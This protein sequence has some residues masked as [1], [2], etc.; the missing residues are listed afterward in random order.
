MPFGR[1]A[2]DN[3]N[4]PDGEFTQQ[5]LQ[6]LR[7][8]GQELRN[9]RQELD[10]SRS[11]AKL[12]EQRILDLAP[13]HPLPI[14]Q[15]HIG[16]A[17]DGV[18][19]T[20]VGN[21][22]SG[23]VPKS[24]LVQELQE[25][26]LYIQMLEDEV[27]ANAIGHSGT[28]GGSEQQ[29]RA[30]IAE[31][32]QLRDEAAKAQTLV[33]QQRTH[34]TQLEKAL[35]DALFRNQTLTNGGTSEEQAEAMVRAL[36]SEV[37]ELE[38]EK[39]ALLGYVQDKLHHT[40]ETQQQ[41]DVESDFA[42]ANLARAKAAESHLENNEATIQQLRSAAEL[43]EQQ[44]RAARE[45]G[46]QELASAGHKYEELYHGERARA[47]ALARQIAD[48]AQEVN[49][50]VALHGEYIAGAEQLRTEY[51]VRRCTGAGSCQTPPCFFF[52]LFFCF[53]FVQ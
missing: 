11:Y 40:A 34:A 6:K 31:V 9:V 44:L 49:E 51:E 16:R 8:Q 27:K 29:T 24:A 35:Q 20:G 26:R 4:G 18:A 12:C 21:G 32:Q 30:L 22:N 28:A 43:A 38:T 46:L 42:A 50:I 36:Q 7:Q 2:G 48:K 37:T 13:S 1:S 19:V 14:S 47:D 15:L 23:D 10:S 52:C 3:A 39:Q 53:C 45:E 25:Q 33:L 5:V 17:V 41:L